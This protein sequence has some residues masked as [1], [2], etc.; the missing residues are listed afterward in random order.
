MAEKLGKEFLSLTGN[1]LLASGVIAYLGVFSHAYRSTLVK[2][3]IKCLSKRNVDCTAAQQYAEAIAAGEDAEMSFSLQS[4]IGDPLK[5]QQWII[6]KLPNDALSVDNAI[7]LTISR[8][9]PLMI[10]PQQQASQWIKTQE[11]GGQSG[12]GDKKGKTDEKP[13]SSGGRKEEKTM[14]KVFKMSQD[15]ARQLEMCISNGWPVL[16]ESVGEALDPLLEPLLQKAIFK[17]GSV[18]MIRLGDSS[19]EYSK[20]FRLYMTSKLPNPH[21][22]PETC[23]QVTLLNFV[24]T[25]EGLEDQLL[26]TLVKQEEP[27]TEDKRVRLVGES[28]ESQ[29][30][31]KELEDKILALL[32]ASK[33]NILDD[34]DLIET[35]SASKVTSS[36]IEEKVIDQQKTQL[37]VHHTRQNYRPVAHRVSQLFF[38]V[39]DLG[40]V[41]PMYQF[42]LQWFHNV[43]VTAIKT[44]DKPEKGSGTSEQRL[45]KRL[46]ALNTTFLILLF[47]LVCRSLF[48]KDKLL[49]SFLLALRNQLVDGTLKFP[50]LKLLLMGGVGAGADTQEM[51]SQLPEWVSQVMWQK[52]I[53]IE[54]LKG[55][56]DDFTANF[57]TDHEQW[58]KVFDAADPRPVA[59]EAS[60]AVTPLVPWPRGLGEKATPLERAL[61]LNA[62][63]PDFVVNAIRDLVED[64][65]GADFLEP[66]SF[67]LAASFAGATNVTPLLFVLSA[68]ADPMAELVKLANSKQM[69]N[70][71]HPISLGQGQGPRAEAAILQAVEEGG[72][73]VLQNCHLA[74]SFLP[75][76]ERTVEALAPETTD[77][78]FRLWL[79]A[80]PSE[81]FPVSILQNG[82]KMTN[83]PP[84]GLRAN[85]LRSYLSFSK[86]WLEA[87]PTPQ[88]WK[89][90][91]FGLCFF[92][93]LILERRKFGP[94]GWNI[95]YEFSQSD[96][97]ICTSQLALFLSEYQEKE[98]P[99][100]ALNYM[101]AEANYGGRVTDVHDR[102]LISHILSDFYCKKV[103]EEDGERY[104]FSPSSVYYAPEGG[105]D[106]HI[107][108]IK[109][110]PLNETP[111]VFGLHMNANLTA[112][113]QEATSLLRAALPLKPPEKAAKQKDSGVSEGGGASTSQEDDFINLAKSI[114]DVIPNEF[115][116][117]AV[118]LKYPV[119]YNESMNTVLV[120][121][122]FR[123]N[124]MIK[125]VSRTLKEV[126]M[127]VKG[128]VHLS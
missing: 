107:A 44:A 1:V 95:P 59:T 78:N 38:V 102:R 97:E 39:S 81:K 42:S 119:S 77:T 23:V 43:Y 58:K 118:I 24:V 108:Y 10:D 55:L 121:E 111:E 30:L 125:V 110:L 70:R 94:L 17:T 80:M 62:I 46:S 31:L 98:I 115:D 3:W 101:A 2:S 33:G 12:G 82:V 91:L 72:W 106:S 113:I 4:T 84:R 123:F 47:N 88:K 75:T 60:P 128:V 35:L 52:F 25:V 79:T 67:D 83:E 120:Q 74:V 14:L 13:N 54:K 65:I 8:R 27:A 34:E 103:L 126:Q 15:Y 127:A 63:R 114:A 57:Q 64:A 112:S 37:Q 56:F 50:C 20:D 36:R 66:P 6:N 29:R 7:I 122:L 53:E 90:L 49:F 40:Q 92:H 5:I 28:A 76:L 117:D 26:A 16:F 104:Y 124:R 89:K 45:Q 18:M 71:V 85:L 32:S 22:S 11:G 86:E 96:K 73:V 105:L 99:W 9:W 69:G 68:G 93:G 61:V 48:E 19:I 87:H 41:D 21:Y 51:P 116:T 100:D 109:G